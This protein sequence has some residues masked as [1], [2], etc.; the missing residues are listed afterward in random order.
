MSS[1]ILSTWT[2][3]NSMK[4]DSI[5]GIGASIIDTIDVVI[6]ITSAPRQLQER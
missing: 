6:R 1:V 2:K 5:I 3:T 4:P